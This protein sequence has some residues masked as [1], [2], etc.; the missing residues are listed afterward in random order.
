MNEVEQVALDFLNKTS[1]AIQTEEKMRQ[2]FT[3]RSIE[4][5]NQMKQAYAMKVSDS[6]NGVTN[7][8]E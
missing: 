2:I 1:D 5:V 7:N 3:D 4:L 8:G 6:L